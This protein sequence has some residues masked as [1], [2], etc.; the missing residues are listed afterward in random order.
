MLPGSPLAGKLSRWQTCPGLQGPW[1]R[2]H[3]KSNGQTRNAP[4]WGIQTEGLTRVRSHCSLLGNRASTR[5]SVVARACVEAR[6]VLVC[7]CAWL[8]V[9]G[10]ATMSGLDQ[11]LHAVLALL[12]LLVL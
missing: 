11:G 4:R 10:G 8:G 5:G 2:E 12:A 6:W 7:L 3:E 1:V 9:P